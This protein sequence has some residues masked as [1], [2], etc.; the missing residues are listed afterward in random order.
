[1]SKKTTYQLATASQKILSRLCDYFLFLC[2]N[3]LITF[4]CIF[5]TFD[6]SYKNIIV[7]HK[8]FSSML[9]VSLAIN[10]IIWYLYFIILCTLWK[11]NT[12]FMKA[13]KIKMHWDKGTKKS[14]VVRNLMSYHAISV[15]GL[16]FTMW[17]VVCISLMFSDPIQFFVSIITLNSKTT[18]IEN[19][20]LVSGIAISLFV[21]FTLPLIGMT[22]LEV[23]NG[24]HQ[25]WLES[26]YGFH[27][28]QTTKKD[29][30]KEI[31]KE[32]KS[33]A[34]PG[35]IEEENLEEL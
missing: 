29:K 22:C 33:S 16:F 9:I 21:I 24:N 19:L 1:M 35:I 17:F 10:S 5:W 14:H 23:A 18:N 28:I 34:L 31:K 20:Q 32:S 12:I 25:T 27:Y 11:G 13:F 4:L 7:D 6:S 3:V 8:I 2:I 15:F 26:R 30:Q